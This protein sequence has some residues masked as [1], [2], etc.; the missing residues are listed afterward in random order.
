MN[1]L[2]IFFEIATVSLVLMLFFC[3]FLEV[4]AVSVPI[5]QTM[6]KRCS[7]RDWTSDNVPETTLLDI[8]QSA[9][10]FSD[11][12]RN[13][14]LVG[15]DYSLTLF[16]AN[17][18]GT[19]LYSPQQNT[20]VVH[21]ININKEILRTRFNQGFPS[22]A[23]AIVI[24]VWN[25]AV[26]NNPYY[27]SV[28]AGCFVQN[29]Y[30][31]SVSHNL[32]TVCVALIDSASLRTD[33]NLPSIMTPILVMPI[34]YP[35]TPYSS[36]SPDYTKMN[37][38][39][40]SVEYSSQ[41]YA[42]G[43]KNLIYVK[44][45]SSQGLSAQ[46]MSQLLWAAY[47]YSSTGHRTV[48]SAGPTYGLQ[49]W[50]SNS[51]GIYQYNP[52]TH[53]VTQKVSGD[54]RADITGTNQGQVGAVNAPAVFLIAYDSLLGGDSG[55]IPHNW[56]IVEAGC[57]AQQLLV[58]ASAWG[59]SGNIVSLGLEEWNGAKAASIRS[60]FGVQQSIIPLLL[61][62]IGHTGLVPELS[63]TPKPDTYTSSPDTTSSPTN[64]GSSSL[65]PSITPKS[66]ISE[67]PSVTTT[68]VS[69]A[70][71]IVPIVMVYSIVLKRKHSRKIL[72]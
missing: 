48:P 56:P 51:T 58:E 20:L 12:H 68:I 27:A 57:V 5:E 47:G 66:S 70:I 53:S 13:V 63:E 25:Q 39:L 23:N 11:N 3:F 14:P 42:E 4:S 35:N 24:V 72:N 62:P 36:P 49:I 2:K 18:T 17:S 19:Y 46:E 61:L 41:S 32:G 71:V 33:L 64:S 15:N 37:G 22:N 21:D 67:F 31:S 7:V 26:M 8:L 52:Q 69:I 29:F 28:E 34:G 44:S 65:A 60:I 9:Y 43:L 16:V 45:W 55:I 6:S 40:P 10:G 38:N 1:K 54:K 50:L 30:L 59:M